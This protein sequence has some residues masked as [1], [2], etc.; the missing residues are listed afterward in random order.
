M[1]VF[2]PASLAAVVSADSAR[3]RSWSAAILIF[4]AAVVGGTIETLVPLHLGH[5]GY[6][7]AGSRWC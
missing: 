5:D 7:P 1:A 6:A 4:V 3:P 2:E